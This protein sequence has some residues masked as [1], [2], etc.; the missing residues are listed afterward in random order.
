[1]LS[2]FYKKYGM[3][4]DQFVDNLIDC[5]VTSEEPKLTAIRNRLY[6]NSNQGREPYERMY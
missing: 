1:M 6:I 3:K 4:V 5:K 2:E